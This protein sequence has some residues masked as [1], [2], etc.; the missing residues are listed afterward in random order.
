[1]FFASRLSTVKARLYGGVWLIAVIALS[2]CQNIVGNFGSNLE[3]SAETAGDLDGNTALTSFQGFEC[4]PNGSDISSRAIHKNTRSELIN[5]LEGFVRGMSQNP[6]VGQAAWNYLLTQENLLERLPDEAT[7]HYKRNSADAPLSEAT[8]RSLYEMAFSLGEFIMSN[9]SR[10][11]DWFNGCDSGEDNISVPCAQ[12]FA[13][14]MWQS[15][16]FESGTPEQINACAQMFTNFP[17]YALQSCLVLA[18]LSPDLGFSLELGEGQG[19]R[20]PLTDLELVRRLTRIFWNGKAPSDYLLTLA[21]S[22]LVRER[23]DT[24]LNHIFESSHFEGSIDEFITSYIRLDLTKEVDFSGNAG[25]INRRDDLNLNFLEGVTNYRQ[26]AIDEALRFARAMILEN[27]QFNDLFQ[28]RES[29]ARDELAQVYGLPAYQEGEPAPL[30]PAGERAG[31]LTLSALHLTPGSEKRHFHL[32][33]QMMKSFLCRSNPNAG[34]LEE[35]IQGNTV[36]QSENGIESSVERSHALTSGP[37]CSFCHNSINPLGFS[38]SNIGPWGDYMSSS[39]G[40]PIYDQETG[41]FIGFATIG[42]QQTHRL[43]RAHQVTTQ[44]PA[45]VGQMLLATR[46]PQAC[47]AQHYFRFSLG[48]DEDLSSTD[49]CALQEFYEA[50]ANPSL[51]IKDAM[52]VF[53]KSEI[54]MTRY[55]GEMSQ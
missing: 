6:A 10:R 43:Y 19:D 5:K 55:V 40:E 41:A 37:Q 45:Q 16:R 4:N 11:S 31:L 15:L 13:E 30:H 26:Q 39:N 2:G 12:Q 54:F 49:A 9:A 22:G 32:G 14:K 53:A 25:T 20:L 47:F 44:T 23:Y 34:E 17:D 52:K 42:S 7:H 8:A 1:M 27:R 3:E 35:I 46:L 28:S 18:F 33:Y 24:V 36:P 29:F 38:L 50:L 48:R 51:S 21:E